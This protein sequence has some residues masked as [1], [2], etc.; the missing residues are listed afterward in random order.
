[1]LPSVLRLSARAAG[2]A[3][4][5][6][7]AVV[8]AGA[9][10]GGGRTATLGGWRRKA[11]GVLILADAKPALAADSDAT[12]PLEGLVVGTS[13]CCPPRNQHLF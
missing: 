10:R 12:V 8:G 6:R 11:G 13:R 5:G 1:M 9:G 4:A 2:G 7:L 3:S